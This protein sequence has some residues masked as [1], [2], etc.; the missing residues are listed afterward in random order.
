MEFREAGCGPNRQAAALNPEPPLPNSDI[1][2]RKR[3]NK[4]NAWP[5]RHCGDHAFSVFKAARFGRDAIR[6][7]V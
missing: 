1:Q 4:K 3:T 6:W 2:N 7:F 5:P